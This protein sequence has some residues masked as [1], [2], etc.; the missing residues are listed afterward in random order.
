MSFASVA[1]MVLA[2]AQ[3]GSALAQEA[4]VPPPPVPAAGMPVAPDQ[5]APPP[6]APLYQL[7]QR[8]EVED[9]A[10]PGFWDPCTISGVHRGAYEVTCNYTASIRRD[11]H[12]RPVGGQPVT[13]TAAPPVTGPP[14]G[15]GAIV[16][17]SPMYL[18]DRWQL[19]VVLRNRLAEVNAYELRCGGSDYA[20]GP[21]MVRIDPN[22][23]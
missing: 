11:I 8:V 6:A 13:Q 10:D 4:G 12:V 7:Y 16:L 21:E 1:L 2:T 15:R 5:S 22:A 23:P 14:F 19:C 18:P 20:V 3:A 9:A 17:A